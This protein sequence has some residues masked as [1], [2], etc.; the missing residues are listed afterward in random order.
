MALSLANRPGTAEEEALVARVLA[1][2]PPRM[3]LP[4]PA[5]AGRSRPRWQLRAGLAGLAAAAAAVALVV[6]SGGDPR[7]DAVAVLSGASRPTPGR[8]SLDLPHAPYLPSR[9]DEAFRRRLDD[10]LTDFVSGKEPTAGTPL[11][12]LFLYRGDPGDVERAEQVLAL[13]PAGPERDNDWAVIHLAGGEPEK[14][15]ELLRGVLEAR[16]DYG[17]A[18]FNLALALEA[19]GRKPEAARALRD[20]L[21]GADVAGPEAAWVAEARERLANLEQADK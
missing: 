8:L 12:A 21:A 6:T 20:Y 4:L 1:S 19:L 17:P 5:A 15:L 10:A 16:P 11:A 3:L 14:A 9:G 13:T 7:G 18:R 2:P